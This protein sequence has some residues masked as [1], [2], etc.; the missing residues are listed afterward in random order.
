MERAPA[1]Q[2]L[3]AGL[4]SCAQFGSLAVE[5]FFN[6]NRARCYK[7]FSMLNSDN[8]EILNDQKYKKYKKNSAFIRLI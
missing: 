1:A 2:W 3:R 7:T 6:I 5:I 8:H 4:L